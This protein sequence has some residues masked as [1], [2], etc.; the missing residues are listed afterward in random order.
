[1]E[2][3]HH[4]FIHEHTLEERS[5]LID[6]L[7]KVAKSNAVSAE[8]YNAG[9]CTESELDIA[10]IHLTDLSSLRMAME[11]LKFPKAEIEDILAH[12][13]AHSNVT[14]SFIEIP[15]YKDLR[16]EGYNILVIKDAK[17]FIYQPRIK[18]H[19]PDSWSEEKQSEI[20][21]KIVRAPEEYGNSLSPDDRKILGE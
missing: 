5:A 1:M 20:L 17:G 13:N 2:Q 4:N 11:I 15:E 8:Q 21:R 10:T 9:K 18:V 16:N 14:D 3:K 6:R 19:I 7:I 12:E